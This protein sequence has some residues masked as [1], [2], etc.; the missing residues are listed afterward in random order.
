MCP[1]FSIWMCKCIQQEQSQQHKTIERVFLV[2]KMSEKIDGEQWDDPK[3]IH[4][5]SGYDKILEYWIL[6]EH[7]PQYLSLPNENRHKSF[8]QRISTLEIIL[9]TCS[10]SDLCLQTGS[11]DHFADRMQ[12]RVL[13]LQKAQYRGRSKHFEKKT[14]P[15]RETYWDKGLEYSEKIQQNF[16]RLASQVLGK[17]W[18][19]LQLK[20][21]EL[22]KNPEHI[23]E[24]TW[25]SSKDCHFSSHPQ[26]CAVRSSILYGPSRCQLS[27]L[28]GLYLNE[29]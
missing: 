6:F 10:S 4:N 26:N 29:S 1:Q 13:F 27:P 19:N 14:R 24:I 21:E 3:K 17:M 8:L 7:I 20:D 28:W 23:L 11:F 25:K 9:R 15:I 12:Q 2:L 18:K 22:K 16:L 5:R